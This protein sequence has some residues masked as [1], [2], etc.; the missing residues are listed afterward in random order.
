MQYHA[1]AVKLSTYAQHHSSISGESRG[2]RQTPVQHRREKARKRETIFLT[3]CEYEMRRRR[4]RRASDRQQ[5]GVSRLHRGTRAA[6][7]SFTALLTC[8]V[9]K[10]KFSMLTEP[11]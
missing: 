9:V 2:A 1:D 3:H 6:S 4:E 7:A 11:F 10:K 5:Q 8:P